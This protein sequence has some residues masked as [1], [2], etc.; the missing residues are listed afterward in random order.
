M[1][2]YFFQ[3]P[4]SKLRS[5]AFLEKLLAIIINC[6]TTGEF[7]FL[8]FSVDLKITAV[9]YIEFRSKFIITFLLFFDYCSDL[10]PEFTDVPK[11]EI[12]VSELGILGCR[13]LSSIRYSDEYTYLLVNGSRT[14]L[15][16]FPIRPLKRRRALEQDEMIFPGYLIN[17]YNL[18][19]Y[20]QC[21]IFDPN[22]MLVPVVSNK[23]AFISFPGIFM[24][25]QCNM[26]SILSLA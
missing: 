8:F 19:G 14:N 1:L 2:L 3:E 7:E 13:Y 9:N 18:T 23:S 20:Y 12:R 25:L 26:L 4:E 24:I 17:S 10:T 11:L 21:S 6:I 15:P 16:L 22:N 5:I